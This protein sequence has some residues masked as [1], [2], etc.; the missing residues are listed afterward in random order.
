MDNIE[1]LGIE[2]YFETILVYETEG[3]KKPN[4]EIFERA[5]KRLNVNL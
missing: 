3:I 1:A 4:P 2:K 5:L